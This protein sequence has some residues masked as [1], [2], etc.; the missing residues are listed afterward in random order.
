[1]DNVHTVRTGTCAGILVIA[2]LAIPG[3]AAQ[4]VVGGALGGAVRGGVLARATG[5]SGSRGAAIGAAA[6]AARGGAQ[7]QQR[8]QQAAQQAALQ[9]EQDRVRELELREAERAA[10]ERA[11]AEFEAELQAQ[12]AQQQQ[13]HVD[14][15]QPGQMQQINQ[16]MPPVEIDMWQ[17]PEAWD[18]QAR[19]DIR[20]I[21]RRYGPEASVALRQRVMQ[22]QRMRDEVLQDQ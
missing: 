18:E 12:S 10:E 14:F 6:G 1:M 8:E 7:R 20:L 13:Q 17:H 11:R 3:A 21:E 9:A 4:D 2:A 5:G 22:L 16:F 15:R 19:Q